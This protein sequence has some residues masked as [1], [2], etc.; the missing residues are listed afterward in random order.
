MIR[1]VRTVAVLAL[2]VGCAS[3]EESAQSPDARANLERQLGRA[4][5]SFNGRAYEEALGQYSALYLAALSGDYPGIA[6]E[7]AAQAATIHS[8]EGDPAE[9]DRWMTFA[10]RY[11]EDA[12][13]GAATR[14]LLARGIRQ[15]KA[16]EERAAEATF[17][18]LVVLCDGSGLEIR[19]MQAASL[20]ALTT[21]GE[22]QLTWN[23]RAIEAAQGL[24]EPRWEAAL[25]TNHGWLLEA[26]AEHGD[27]L[28]SFERARDLL[29][30]ATPSPMERLQAEW[31]VGHGL[32]LAGRA[33]EARGV[34]EQVAV[35]GRELYA[36]RPEA[37]QAE[38]LGR[39]E[40]ELGELDAAEGDTEAAVRRLTSARRRLEEAGA[41]KAA[42]DLLRTLDRRLG[43]LQAP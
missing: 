42:P 35:R 39:A 14:V 34:L 21:S 17:E 19:A 13:A 18:E 20:A 37:R 28:R 9:S 24:G 3:T 27:A 11:A 31:G 30:E 43:Q 26:R 38:W 10:E 5:E 22:E 6:A 36:T 32:R 33:A 4:D 15:W 23:L 29:L 8:L 2:L 40:W 7:A 41:A 12:G 1:G 25:W 16:G